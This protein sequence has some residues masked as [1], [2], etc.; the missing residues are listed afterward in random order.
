MLAK[1]YRLNKRQIGLIYKK[2]KRQN[3]GFV[4]VKFSSNGLLH[5]RFAIVIP[6]SVVKKVVE[7]NRLRRVISSEIEKILKEG[8]ISLRADIIIRL[9][10]PAQDEK[11]LRGKINEV[12]KNV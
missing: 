7:R 5:P 4:G 10:N 12:L 1:K 3:F 6:K 9:F 2:G 8:E 11:S